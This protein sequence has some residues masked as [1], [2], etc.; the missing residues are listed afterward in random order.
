MTARVFVK[1]HK[2]HQAL[3]RSFRLAFPNIVW[4]Y[5]CIIAI[6]I[7]HLLLL[8]SGFR[9]TPGMRD[10]LYYLLSAQAETLGSL[11]VLAF[12][13][14]LVAAQITSRYTHIMVHRVI[15]SWAL[16]YAVPFVVGILLPLFLLQG[17]FYLWSTEVSL[18]VASYCVL[19]LLPFAV[20]VRR[21]LSISATISDMKQ[22]LSTTDEP[23]TANVIRRLGNIAI[24]ALNVKD[25]E[26]FELGVRE[27]MEGASAGLDLSK[28]KLLI[29]KEI[30]Q[31]SYAYGR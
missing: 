9:H 21:L 26:T 6:A 14:T 27:L 22:E 23:E 1:L 13:F 20:A 8:L 24:G 17:Y 2:I 15:G 16:W 3:W 18:L 12:T 10:S 31:I 25:Y 30:A 5:A 19:S 7:L 4:F 11:F 28:N 29:V